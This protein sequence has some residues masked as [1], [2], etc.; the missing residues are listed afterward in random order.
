MSVQPFLLLVEEKS[1]R[2]TVQYGVSVAM[3]RM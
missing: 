2:R 3:D 1:T